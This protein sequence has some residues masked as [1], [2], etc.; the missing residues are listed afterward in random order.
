M[1][2]ERE[3][4]HL[5]QLGQ[6][7]QIYSNWWFC[8]SYNH[9]VWGFL[10]QV[11]AVAPLFLWNWWLRVTWPK[12]FP[13]QSEWQKPRVP[14]HVCVSCH[15]TS[16]NWV[17]ES[18][19]DKA[20]PEPWRVTLESLVWPKVLKKLFQR[21]SRFRSSLFVG[22]QQIEPSKHLWIPLMLICSKYWPFLGGGAKERYFH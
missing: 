4:D 15:W 5:T 12:L 16:L 11:L 9:S 1:E 3:T 2:R 8:G 21:S 14:H 18:R 7:R 22:T 20:R 17:S 13:P 10:L 19:T 6:K